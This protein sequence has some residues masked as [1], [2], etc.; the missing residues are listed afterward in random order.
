MDVA[1]DAQDVGQGHTIGLV[2]L[3]ASHRMPFSIAG[4]RHRV[5]REHRPPGPSKCSNYEATRRFDRD[6]DRVLG[7]V[8]SDRHGQLI[9]RHHAFAARM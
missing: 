8:A 9:F 1:V 7:P 4:H 2:G 3:G 5:D 6:G